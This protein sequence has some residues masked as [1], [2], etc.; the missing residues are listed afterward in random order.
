V[1]ADRGQGAGP[2]PAR[3]R[4]KIARFTLIWI[5]AVALA[6]A[7]I[8]A[9]AAVADGAGHGAA[10]SRVSSTA[11][12]D[13]AGSSSGNLPARYLGL[14][15]ESGS[16][17]NSGSFDD[18]GNLP[19]L[20][21]NLGPGILRFGGNSVDLTYTGASPAALAGLDRLVRATDWQVMY[22]VNLGHFNAGR[23]SRDARAVAGALGGYLTSIACGNEP[24]DYAGHG[25]SGHSGIRSPAYTETDYL[26]EAQACIRAVRTGAPAA[27]I[28]G[29]DTAHVSWLPQYAAVEKGTISLL[30][31]HYYPLSACH[32]P[33][34]A[35]AL[36]S[37]ATAAGEASAVSAAAA[38]TAG[39]S[40]RMSETNS[41]ACGGIPGVSNTY[42]AALWAVDYLLTGAEHGATGM[43]FHGFLAHTCH[44][45]TPLC[46]VGPDQYA[47]QPV[48][49]GLLF[50]HLLGT[51]ELLPV[52]VHPAA[53]I[54]A[55]A[56]RSAGGAIR[57]V[58][59]N[60]SGAA[61]GISLRAGSVSGTATALRLTGPSLT[62]T[63]G[64][65]IQGAQVQ[66]DGTFTLHAPSRLACYSGS[67]RV[68]VGAY[69]AV[70]VALPGTPAGPS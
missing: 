7:V 17:V 61:V 53:S 64:V 24:D 18:V 70:M 55:H 21:E 48:Y 25:I 26:K 12:V 68:E 69:S 44:G 2:P 46:Q 28:S 30:T 23:V 59:E 19:R 14:S 10:P 27:P 29:P 47:A 67:C 58:I 66:P 32:G 41:A 62:A 49:Y 20:L 36:L 65:R 63:S 52:T 39:V 54:A 31:V 1:E 3:R 13:L 9:L 33:G 8:V 16:A 22:S 5:G 56:L 45:Y 4:I 43:N 42:A 50:T 37:R 11:T 6:V 34:T 57:V 15:F 35:A 38:H 51:G 60:L 40:L